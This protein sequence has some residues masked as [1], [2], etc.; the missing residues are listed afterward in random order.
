MVETEAMKHRRVEV[1]DVNFIGDGGSAEFVGRAVDGAAFDAA[2]GHDYR[3]GFSVMIA[4]RVFVAIAIFG[5]FST[6]FAAPDNERAVKEATLF[7]VSE[8]GGEGTVDL[9]GFGGEF[10]AEVLVVVPAVVPDLDNADA[11]LDKAAGDKEL[12]ALLGVAV[13]GAGGFRFFTEV[14]CIG[15]LGLHAESNFV[16]FETGLEGRFALE[17]LG[18]YLVELVDEIELSA[19]LVGGDVAVADVLDHLLHGGGGSID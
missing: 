4:A 10:F 2:A 18:V 8:E 1:V 13:G 12:F 16:G 5:R 3:E 6:E 14:E 17:V 11:A 15:G 19:L 9:A 7:E